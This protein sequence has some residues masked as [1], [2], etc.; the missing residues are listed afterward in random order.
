MLASASVRSSRPIANLR[1]GAKPWIWWKPGAH[2]GA[3]ESELQCKEAQEQEQ[4]D[5]R[6]TL[7]IAIEGQVAPGTGGQ[8]FDHVTQTTGPNQPRINNH[9]D[10][11]FVATYGLGAPTD[12]VERR[13]PNGGYG[14]GAGVFAY[15]ADEEHDRLRPIALGGQQTEV[16]T[17]PRTLGG[18]SPAPVNDADQI[19]FAVRNIEGG[20]A[21]SA[22]FQGD[23]E[24]AG[25]E[26]LVRQGQRAPGGG[27]FEEFFEVAQN[28]QGDVAFT[29]T[30]VGDS[31]AG[32]GVFLKRHDCDEIEEIV[33]EGEP[34]YGTDGAFLCNAP[35]GPWLNNHEVVLF[36]ANCITRGTTPDLELQGS[37][38]ITKPGDHAPRLFVRRGDDPNGVPGGPITRIQIGQPGV[39]DE[40]LAMFLRVATP[41]GAVIVSKKLDSEDGYDVCAIEGQNL[42][43]GATLGLLF[44]GSDPLTGP[45]IAEN[46]VIA[47]D[48]NVQNTTTRQGSFICKDLRVS[49]AALE[50]DRKPVDTYFRYGG[51]I[52][53]SSD[54]H[55]STFMDPFEYPTGVFSARTCKPKK[56][57]GPLF[58]PAPPPP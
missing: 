6:E 27:Y 42:G 15:D 46:G 9:G 8:L 30:L 49:A 29:A 3:D 56:V 4:C 16:G 43:Y 57:E 35:N 40:E 13:I 1:D 7:K 17:L 5:E 39:N 22:I 23:V 26:V 2:D 53:T 52:F 51:L 25:L 31:G 33:R 20:S 19:A 11:S 48:G 45:S 50:G 36:Q 38:F 58:P 37:V 41:P 55:H 14:P 10:V 21:T 18:Y 47:F 24:H 12:L 28:D 44:E 34:L 32:S 54:D